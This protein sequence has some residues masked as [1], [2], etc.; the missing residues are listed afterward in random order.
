VFDDSMPGDKPVSYA[1]WIKNVESLSI[2]TLAVQLRQISTWAWQPRFSI[3][4]AD[5]D[6][7]AT[8]LSACLESVLAQSYPYWELCVAADSSTPSPAQALLGRYVAQDG[9]VKLKQ[10]QT[11]RQ[12]VETLNTSLSLACGDYILLPHA[13][14]KLPPHALYAV[15][16]ALQK[17]PTA[18]LIYSD[19]DRLD[20]RGRRC[21]P[22][23]KPD[24]CPD[25]LYSQN[26]LSRLTIYRRS[27][28]ESVG[29]F[30]EGFQGGEEYDLALRCSASVTGETVLHIPQILCHSRIHAAPTHNGNAE[31][32]DASEAG[33]RALQRFF[34]NRSEKLTVSVIGAGLYRQ[35]RPLP[36][37]PPLVTLIIPT[38]DAYHILNKCIDSILT[39]TT[40]PN[41]EIIIVD[42]QTRCSQTLAYFDEI[43]KHPKVR[44]LRYDQPFNY[45]AINNFAAQHA[46][47]EV[48]G[49]V[50]NDV[51]VITPD[52]LSEMVAHVIRPEIGCVGAKL[53][54]PDDTIQHAG[55]ILGLGGVAGHSHKHA[56]RS[57]SGYFGRL[58]IVHNVSA[59]TGAALLIRKELFQ[60]VGGLDEQQLAVTFNDVDLCLK[61]RH[62][63]FYNLWTPFAEL[64][65]H[66]SKTR[67]A[68]K[69]PEKQARFK[70][71]CEVMQRR[72]KHELYKDPCYSPHLTLSRED[73]STGMH[74]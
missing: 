25:L 10:C 48:L 13:G 32:F 44:V 58:K 46:E 61:V 15:A 26:Y 35:Q 23:F 52:W 40:Y 19:Q 12:R 56:A 2:P 3:V 65:H 45:S 68:D 1:D 42:N 7:S 50:N 55:V 39:R 60:L 73:Y 22:F 59:V 16:E 63:G 47:G 20:D 36:Q 24:W 17:H 21:D 4:I 31:H 54:Y 11:S 30:H 64:Y 51:Q 66:E 69:T 9:R 70:R 33:C 74:T 27:L 53:Y 49:L 62:A 29:G 71:E 14:D 18:Q 37:C 72:W 5:C 28:V 41:Y 38:R 34:D 43:S 8:D 57:A 6:S 67:G